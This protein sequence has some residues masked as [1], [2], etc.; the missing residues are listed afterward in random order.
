MVEPTTGRGSNAHTSSWLGPLLKV[1]EVERRHGQDTRAA[2][3][4]LPDADTPFG[5]RIWQRC[6]QYVVDHAVDRRG[7]ADPQG[8]RP[9][10]QGRES[11]T[12]EETAQSQSEVVENPSHHSLSCS[13]V[14][15]VG[16]GL[17]MLHNHGS[18]QVPENR[19]PWL[20]QLGQE[21]SAKAYIR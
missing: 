1:P 13:I 15:S 19:D 18:E 21:Q 17:R 3:R 4:D 10:D 14:S 11:G 6:E 16:P 12:A 5:A 7:R 9:E 8:A 20:V 2:G